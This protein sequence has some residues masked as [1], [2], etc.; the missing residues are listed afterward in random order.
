[1]KQILSIITI[2]LAIIAAGAAYY[3]GRTADIDDPFATEKVELQ[4]AEILREIEKEKRETARTLAAIDRRARLEANQGVSFAAVALAMT[5]RLSFP[6][7]LFSG[8]A[9][10]G[11]YLYRKP[12]LFEF[13]GVRAF[14]P[15]HAVPDVTQQALIAKQQAEMVKAL[16][17]AESVTQERVTQIIN[18]VKALKPGRETINIST[19]AAL[20]AMQET[21][22]QA[23]NVP[24]DRA[25][26]DFQQGS[27]LIGYD[28][29]GAAVR[30]P[31]AGFVSCAFGGG[32]GS[33]KTSKL[34][35][36][37]AQM[38]LQGVNVSILDAHQGNA[39]SLVDSLGLLTDRSNVRIFPA[40]ETTDAVKTMLTDVDAA[41]RAGK[42]ADVPC[43]YVLDELRPLNRACS[44]VET[45]MDRIS[46]EGRKFGVFG[47]FSS[48]TW[49][50][51]MFGKSGSAARDA[52]VLKMAAKMPK[53]Q[54]R[55]LFKDGDAARKVA[56]LAMPEMYASSMIFDGVVNVPYVTRDDL[57]ALVQK[58]QRMTQ[59]VTRSEKINEDA[60]E[61]A[62]GEENAPEVKIDSDIELISAIR[63]KNIGVN[64][65]A[66]QLGRDRSQISKALNYGIMT[67]SLRQALY[68]FIMYP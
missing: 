60:I 29:T 61:E 36:L 45:L 38:I 12:V 1:M 32:S 50:A 49:E 9:G 27:V 33:G 41:I 5:W 19:Q 35:L 42:P 23:G 25:V 2:L 30:F 7:L 28:M 15:R 22:Q 57:D 55:T 8:L 52:C 65:L 13:E 66:R 18:T 68:K 40:I 56:K 43:V 4:R 14:L 16:A 24:F 10:A 58:S 54:A 31:L 39:Q 63:Q 47:L 44:G 51:S 53:E 17:Y 48:Q 21:P 64:E 34:R 46:N 67:P 6:I 3:Y 20:P 11:V 37:V 26:N 59:P 62:A